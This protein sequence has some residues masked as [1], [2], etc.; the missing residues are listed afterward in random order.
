MSVHLHEAVAKL[1]V[2]FQ[3]HLLPLLP[4]VVVARHCQL[5][6]LLGAL[7]Q[8]G[9]HERSLVAVTIVQVVAQK[10]AK[11]GRR[12][13]GIEQPGDARAWSK[14][15]INAVREAPGRPVPLVQGWKEPLMKQGSPMIRPRTPAPCSGSRMVKLPRGVATG[16]EPEGM[17]LR[18][19]VR[20]VKLVHLCWKGAAYVK[21]SSGFTV[22]ASSLMLETRTEL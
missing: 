21:K 9:V 17:S 15:Y 14:R 2:L 7:G 20:R 18:M 12:R 22:S 5:Q 19:V 3:Q 10:R 6:R 13:D 1:I 16:E 4:K 11:V 8:H